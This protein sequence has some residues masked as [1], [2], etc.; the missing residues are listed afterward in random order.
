MKCPFCEGAPQDIFRVNYKA[1]SD[2]LFLALSFLLEMHVIKSKQHD[3]NSGSEYRP[4]NL[5]RSQFSQGH[6]T[7]HAQIT[8]TIEYKY[9]FRGF[10]SF[11]G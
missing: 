6:F 5:H 9:D 7:H 11:Y 10:L 2:L 8:R 1:R 3:N 4:D